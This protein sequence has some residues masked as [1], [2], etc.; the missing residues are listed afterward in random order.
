M[1]RIISIVIVLG[2][3]GFGIYQAVG[4]ADRD[5]SGSI[6]KE[7]DL[8]VFDLRVNDCVTDLPK[9]DGLQSSVKASPCDKP[10]EGEVYT[11]IELGDGDYPGDAFVNGKADR[12]C[13][14]RLR[15]LDPP[16]EVDIFYFT[17]TKESWDADEGKTVK[18]IAVF[19][20]PATGALKDQ[21]K[22]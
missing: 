14:A 4:E 8:N 18:C 2:V 9:S 15:R 21:K 12:G 16:V 22:S 7:G 19:A 17:P 11:V 3:I 10:H 6:E 20:K 1:G 5:D 13:P